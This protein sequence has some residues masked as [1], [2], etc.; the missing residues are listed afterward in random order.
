M[1]RGQEEALEKAA[2][3]EKPYIFKKKSHQVQ[4]DFNEQVAACIDNAKDE[5]KKRPATGTGL[6]KALESLEEGTELLTTRQ[7][8]I[9]IADR[10]E[11]GWKVVEEY[12]ADELASGSEDEK[13][14]ERAERTAERKAVKKRKAMGRQGPRSY[15]GKFRQPP[16]GVGAQAVSWPR[17]QSLQPAPMQVRN[18]QPVSRPTPLVGPCFGCGEMGHLRRYCPKTVP[19]QARWYPCTEYVRRMDGVT[20]ESVDCID[21]KGNEDC[22]DCANDVD[23]GVDGLLESSIEGT[24]YGLSSPLCDGGV[25]CCGTEG[26]RGKNGMF[27]K[28]V[29]EYGYSS[30]ERNHECTALVDQ[31]WEYERTTNPVSVKGKLAMSIKF[32][33]EVLQAPDYIVDVIKSG[34]VMPFSSLPTKFCKWNQNSALVNVEF[35]DQAINEL[36]ADGRVREVDEQPWVCSPL[37]VVES[38]TGKKRLVLNLRHVNK[39]LQK[40]RFKYEDLRIAILLFERGDYMFTFDLKSGYHH[41][42]ICSGQQTYLGFSWVKQGTRRFYVFTVLP[43]GLATACYIFT[44]LLRPLVK[45]WRGRG[46]KVV[47]YLDDGIGAAGNRKI[48]CEASECV[49]DTLTKAG[50]VINFEKS[51]WDPSSKARWLGFLLDLNKGCLSVPPEKIAALENRL[52]ALAVQREVRARELASVTGKLIAMSPGI[53]HVSRL[54]TRAMYALIESRSSWCEVL[55]VNEQAIKV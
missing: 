16:L 39:F 23:E 26:N 2:K 38:S 19:G 24:G 53:G 51:H 45:Y 44:K 35:V 1:Q 31:C 20:K 22:V 14:L 15:T 10:S 41:V 4:Y 48:A 11:L 3:R 21:V 30:S 50:F 32:W 8:L 9:R 17:S 55:T 43:F 47:V 28:E 12:E 36:L 5:L 40:Q 34:Y 6:A 7:K 46:M 37:S 49:R 27:Q 54:M 25:N 29:S 52:A 13:K 42:D 18:P 33:E